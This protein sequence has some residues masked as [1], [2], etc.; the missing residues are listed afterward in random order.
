MMPGEPEVVEE[1][2]RRRI[3]VPVDDVTYT[4][5]TALAREFGLIDVL[6]S[7]LPTSKL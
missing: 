6:P 7:P 3:G 2:E 4:N 5:F 1:T